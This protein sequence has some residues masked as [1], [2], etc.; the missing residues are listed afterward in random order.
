VAKCHEKLTNKRKDFLHKLSNEITNQYD[1]ICLE[2]L[3]IQ[4]MIKNRKLSKHIADVSWG[5]FVRQIE[6]KSS[7]KGKNVMR[8]GTFYPSSKMCS[9]GK[10][11]NELKLHQRIWTCNHCNTT[12]D[13]DL[14]AAENIK[15]FGL[16]TPPNKRQRE[17]IA[18]A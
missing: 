3:N 8:I 4:G 7:W 17:A 10:I 16:R 18:C 13:R 15:K 6:Y 1:T 12:H 2:T 14:L 9:C 11:N 5:E